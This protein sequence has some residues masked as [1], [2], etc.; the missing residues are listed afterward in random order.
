LISLTYFQNN[1]QANLRYFEGMSVVQFTFQNFLC[2]APFCHSQL[3]VLKD[4]NLFAY[5]TIHTDPVYL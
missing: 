2:L 3:S 1:F 4:A 5:N